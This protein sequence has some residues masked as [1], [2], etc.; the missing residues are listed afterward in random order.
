MIHT[1]R[2]LW[3]IGPV[4]VDLVGGFTGLSRSSKRLV[5]GGRALEMTR[6]KGGETILYSGGQIPV[7]KK[8]GNGA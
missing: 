5:G 4:Q 2:R 8:R 1:E 6:K 7:G 3:P